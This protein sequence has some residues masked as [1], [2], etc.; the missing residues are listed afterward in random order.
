MHATRCG[1]RFKDE[2]RLSQVLLGRT[3]PE[4]AEERRTPIID[5]AKTSVSIR[6][7]KESELEE[8]DRVFRLAFGTL[9]PIGWRTTLQRDSRS[10]LLREGLDYSLAS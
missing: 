6:P 9:V 7:L 3:R 1:G 5:E 2:S 4:S 8:A 10:L